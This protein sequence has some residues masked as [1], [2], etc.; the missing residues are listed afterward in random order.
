MNQ[1]IVDY[2]QEN[3]EKYSKDVLVEQLE[4]TGYNTADI[5]ESVAFVYG[6]SSGAK[7]KSKSKF[8]VLGIGCGITTLILIVVVGSIVFYIYGI[9]ED[10]LEFKQTVTGSE[11]TITKS[12]KDDIMKCLQKNDF[13]CFSKILDTTEIDD[14]QSYKGVPLMHWVA[15]NNNRS[16]LLHTL[17]SGADINRI[18]ETNPTRPTPI[19]SAIM[20]RNSENVELLINAGA[21]INI[22]GIIGW[23]PMRYAA[24]LNE[25]GLVLSLLKAGADW[26]IVDNHGKTLIEQIQ[27]SRIDKK[28]PEYENL[29][30]VINFLHSKGVLVHEPK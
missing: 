25:Y 9:G 1:K 13:K 11:K 15:K 19:F 6:S 26:S 8:K 21:N 12:G 20:S 16:F 23:T 5:D 17:E 28:S 14:I 22:V 10:V 29:K 4:K 24:S 27:T 2:L 3:K 30:E 18:D 7:V